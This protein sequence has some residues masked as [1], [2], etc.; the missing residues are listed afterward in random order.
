MN[1]VKIYISLGSIESDRSDRLEELWGSYFAAYDENNKRVTFS[2][3]FDRKEVYSLCRFLAY[4]LE[5]DKINKEEFY[6]CFKK[7]IKDILKYFNDQYI[8]PDGISVYGIVTKE[9]LMFI[10]QHYEYDEMVP[11]KYIGDLCQD[12]DKV[13]T[14]PKKNIVLAQERVCIDSQVYIGDPTSLKDKSERMKHTFDFFEYDIYE[15]YDENQKLAFVCLVHHDSDFYDIKWH[16][17]FIFCMDKSDKAHFILCPTDYKITEADIPQG[18]YKL[19]GRNYFSVRVNN[20]I[21]KETGDK[22]FAMV[23]SDSDEN[24]GIKA[25]AFQVVADTPRARRN[26]WDL[27]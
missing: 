24:Y 4:K 10:P 26:I 5:T 21:N 23:Y 22:N 11:K 18:A 2:N 9:S 16:E 7:S 3:P 19:N 8:C 15:V 1:L 13:L 20:M 27:I 12:N 17:N 25:L 14:R 6:K